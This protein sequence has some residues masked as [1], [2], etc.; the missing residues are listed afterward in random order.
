LIESIEGKQ[1]KPRLK[2][3]FPADV[4]L[5]GCPTTVANVETVAVAPSECRV[6]GWRRCVDRNV[7]RADRFEQLV[8]I[9]FPC[10][11]SLAI[12]RRSGKWFASFG[13]ER[14]HGT[15]LFCVSGHVNAPAV[16]EEE[17]SMP[18]QEMLERHCGGVRGG[19]QNLK[20]VIPGGCSVPV[21]TRDVSEKVLM[22]YDSL[23]DHGTSLGTGAIIVM[24]QSTDMV[25]AIARFVSLEAGPH[26][27]AI[28]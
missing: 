25:A 27:R 12:A 18:L 1:G 21:I 15:K 28:R 22:D 24:D 4:G 14:N 13:R 2:P 23:K 7:P 17:M 9:A 3:P 5:F 11:P 10:P 6:W 19:W 8:F 16:F 20:G 26:T